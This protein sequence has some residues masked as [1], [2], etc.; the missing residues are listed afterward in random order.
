MKCPKCAS[1]R[2]FALA[3]WVIELEDNTVVW[4]QTDD[5]TIVFDPTA[6]NKNKSSESCV[7]RCADCGHKADAGEFR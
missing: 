6:V 3:K 1:Q 5:K 2:R 4:N 7:L